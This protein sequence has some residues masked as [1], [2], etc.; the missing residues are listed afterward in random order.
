MVALVRPPSSR[1]ALFFA[2]LATACVA[3]CESS[4]DREAPCANGTCAAATSGT[5]VT[6]PATFFGNHATNTTQLPVSNCSATSGPRVAG[7]GNGVYPYKVVVPA[8]QRL[9]VR[10]I[11][12]TVFNIQVRL[13][14]GTCP[15]GTPPVC[16]AAS[17][18][19]GSGLAGAESFTWTNTT[20]GDKTM[21][22][23]VASNNSTGVRPFA[24]DLVLETP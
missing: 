14:D 9:K 16:T 12:L 5:A 2:A 15:T 1:S 17:D 22:V 18:V 10:A 23:L 8:G 4:P 11:P 19:S 21:Y 13:Y 24:V 3:S 6:L 7:I 20:A